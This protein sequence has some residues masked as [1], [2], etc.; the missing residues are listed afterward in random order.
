MYLILA[1]KFLESVEINKGF[2][3]L[4]LTLIKTENQ[5]ITIRIAGAITF[6]NYVL[7]NWPIV[8]IFMW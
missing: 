3:L 8:S 4:L 5:D 6:K 1:E 7:R 2:P